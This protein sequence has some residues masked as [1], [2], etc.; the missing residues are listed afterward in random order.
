[1]TK[2]EKIALIERAITNIEVCRC[3][4]SYD[5]NDFYY[6]PNAVNGKFILGQK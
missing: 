2:Q 3:C 4:F 6:Y 5:N 1:M